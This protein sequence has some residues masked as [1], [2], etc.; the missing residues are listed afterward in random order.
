MSGTSRLD[1]C[2]DFVSIL[3]QS[4]R[5]RSTFQYVEAIACSDEP[6]LVTGETGVGKEGM[7]LAVHRVSGRPGKRVSLNVAGLDDHMFSDTLFGHRKGAFT[8]ASETREGLIAQAAGGTLFRDEIGDLTPG[9]QVKLLR[10]LQE[11]SYLPLGSD[12]AKTTDAR[13]VAATNRNLETLLK[14]NAFRADL[15]Y[16]LSTHC[17]HIPPLRER[18]ED[19]PLLAD[20]FLKEAARALNKPTP[21][22]PPGFISLLSS[23]PFPGNIRELRSLIFDAVARHQSGK[24]SL[25]SFRKIR[26]RSKKKSATMGPPSCSVPPEQEGAASLT[27]SGRFPTLEEAECFLFEEAI[28]RAGGNQGI[29]ATLL[30]VTRQ[31]VNRWLRRRKS[32][33]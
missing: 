7:V 4:R 16:R 18:Q 25:K 15:Y 1:R 27:I 29:A 31:T 12:V 14:T 22:L 13:I 30:G 26:E 32:P 23:H 21:I 33:S 9:S 17:I 19:I 8:G 5:M 3:T 24:L 2:E 28:K 20:H 11:R 6:V 10:L